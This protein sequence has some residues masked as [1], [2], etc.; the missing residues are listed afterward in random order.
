[1]IEISCC[2]IKFQQLFTLS[3]KYKL[4]QYIINLSSNQF[5]IGLTAYNYETNRLYL[6]KYVNLLVSLFYT[7]APSF[8]TTKKGNCFNTLNKKKNALRKKIMK[9]VISNV[10]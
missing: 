8:K 5:W 4:N 3:I 6:Q 7:R 10:T 9:C 1:L 2:Y